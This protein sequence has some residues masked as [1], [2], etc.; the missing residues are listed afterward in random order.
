MEIW[1]RAS[2]SSC[3]TLFLE[4]RNPF[5]MAEQASWN[6]DLSDRAVAKVKFDLQRAVF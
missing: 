3:G 4:P 6:S 1:P 2:K 5:A